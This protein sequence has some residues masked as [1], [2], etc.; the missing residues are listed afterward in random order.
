MPVAPAPTGWDPAVRAL[1]L[2]LQGNPPTELPTGLLAAARRQRVVSMVAP[3]VGGQFAAER[4][5]QSLVTLRQLAIAAQ[6]MSGLTAAGARPLLIKG[7]ALAAVAYGDPLA[8][9]PG[10][11]DILVDPSQLDTARDCLATAT[12]TG[13]ALHTINFAIDGVGIEIHH[14]LDPNPAVLAV[15]HDEL[16]QRRLQIDTGAGALATLSR[17]DSLLLTATH[18]G[19]DAWPNLR[20]VLDVHR[21]LQRMS[22]PELQAAR[23]VAAHS[24]AAGQLEVALNVAKPLQGTRILGSGVAPRIARRA[25][26]RLATGVDL[27]SSHQARDVVERNLINLASQPPGVRVATIRTLLIERPQSWGLAPTAGITP[28]IASPYLLARRLVARQRAGTSKP[29]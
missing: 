1:V 15:T 29:I 28:Q 3:S 24:G 23:E 8:R 22:P 12:P 9:G 7:V 11:I 6:L 17:P 5:R 14:R 19:R 25:W 21:L 2:T 13:E 18:G 27:R 20:S 10:D 16:W 26:S 4:R